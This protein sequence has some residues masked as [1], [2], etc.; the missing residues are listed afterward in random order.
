[1]GCIVNEGYRILVSRLLRANIRSM[2]RILVS[3]KDH[4]GTSAVI[5]KFAGPP[6]PPF[7]LDFAESSFGPFSFLLG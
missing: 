5:F 2:G 1:V 6:F 3:H 7:E 4:N